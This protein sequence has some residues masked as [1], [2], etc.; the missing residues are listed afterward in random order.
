MDKDCLLY[1][2]DEAAIRF[3]SKFR[4]EH[5]PGIPGARSLT[6]AKAFLQDYF[7]RDF[8]WDRD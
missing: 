5:I 4:V 6:I 1:P 2:D 7:H 8:P 3:Y